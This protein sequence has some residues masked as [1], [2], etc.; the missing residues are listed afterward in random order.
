M[1]ATS[2]NA[3]HLYVQCDVP[4]SMTLVEWR[5]AHSAPKRRRFSRHAV[6]HLIRRRATTG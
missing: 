2:T 3:P 4:E 6:R 1:L 5:R